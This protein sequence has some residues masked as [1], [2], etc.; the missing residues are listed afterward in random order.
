M[1]TIRMVVTGTSAAAQYVLASMEAVDG[2][3]RVEEIEDLL[4]HLDDADS[5][6]AGL[7]SDGMQKV[8]RF[9]VDV[10]DPDVADRVQAA[11]ERAATAEGA[12]LE[13]DSDDA[14]GR[15]GNE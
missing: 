15:S 1:N 10:P 14:W 2:V 3:A 6:S 13:V 12:V 9:E 4:P 7:V 5:S 8:H 11:A